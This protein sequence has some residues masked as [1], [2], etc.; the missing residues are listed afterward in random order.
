MG[1]VGATEL[2]VTASRVAQEVPALGLLPV[3]VF[4]RCSAAALAS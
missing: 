1:G 2:D 3:T 4:E